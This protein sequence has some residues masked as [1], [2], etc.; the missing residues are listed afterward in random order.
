M[1]TTGPRYFGFV[2]GGTHP[3]AL[4]AA[5]LTAAWDQNGALP[6]MSPVGATLHSVVQQWLVDILQ[7]PQSAQ[8]TFTT[9]A[10]MANAAALA[11]ARDQQLQLHGWDVRAR[12]LFGA[13][14]MTVVVGE[15][16][17]STIAKSLSL[18]GMG[19][20]Q[21]VRVPADAEG[22]LRSDA[23]PEVSGPV[24]VCAQA[25]EVN[26]GAFDP[27]SELA[28][29]TAQRKG[30]LHVDGAFGLW[31]MA[32]PKYAHLLEGVDLADSWATDGHK[33]LNVTYDSG[34]V[35][36][37]GSDDL[38]RTFGTEAS[39]LPSDER[40][41]AML[42]S[43]ET[44]QRL[45]AV[46]LWAV[47]KTLGR[48]G[49]ADLVDRCCEHATEMANLLSAAGLEIVNNVVLNQVLVR[50]EN[51]RQT[52]AMVEAIQAEGTCW[53]GPTRWDGRA[54]MRISVS[55]WNTSTSDIERSAAAI[56]A[57]YK[58]TRERIPEDAMQSPQS[59]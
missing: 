50:A 3:V 52:L 51:D 48:T 10:T 23:M 8:V 16:T 12:G 54:A 25:G 59:P 9:G 34:I 21:M 45:R 38:R 4:A 29:W 27:F 33:W 2:T 20:Q 19:S 56:V 15:R 42:H 32:S 14:E 41:A 13:P 30:W 44:S 53:C 55:S 39:Y 24:I 18:I 37:R 46:E 57:A 40:Y 47:L 36:T 7:L 28:E 58:H 1:A 17:H 43:P 5:W 35:L 49:V 6:L 31:A 26:T 11:A 22:R